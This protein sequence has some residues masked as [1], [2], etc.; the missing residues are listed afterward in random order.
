MYVIN[1]DGCKLVRTHWIALYV[2]SYTFHS[3]GVESIPKEIKKLIRNNNITTN[4]CRIQANN[5]VM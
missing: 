1:L 5:S 4:I 2:I 3:F